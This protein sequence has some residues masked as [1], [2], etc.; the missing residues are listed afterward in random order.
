MFN[1]NPSGHAQEE[2]NLGNGAIDSAV[3]A[4]RKHQR[5]LLIGQIQ[6]GKTGAYLTIARRLIAEKKEFVPTKVI[7]LAGIHG[8]LRDQTQRRAQQEELNADTPGI[9]EV[10]LKNRADLQKAYD[11]V[12]ATLQYLEEKVLIID[13]ESDQASPNTRSDKNRRKGTHERSAVNAKLVELVEIALSPDMAGNERGRYLACTA[14]PAATLLV[15]RTDILSCDAAVLLPPHEEYFGPEDAIARMHV[16]DDNAGDGY[17]LWADEIVL[18]YF[19]GAAL[20]QLD[21]VEPPSPGW[22]LMAHAAQQIQ[23]HQDF[24]KSL[25]ASIRHWLNYLAVPSNSLYGHRDELLQ[26]ALRTHFKRTLD[27]TELAAFQKHAIDWL[28]RLEGNM[29]V[30]NN[31]TSHEDEMAVFSSKVGIVGGNMLSRGITLP[32]LLASGIVRP[33]KENTPYDTVQQWERFCGPR[34]KYENYLSILV[35]Q[36][37]KHAFEEIVSADKDLRA[38]LEGLAADGIVYL[39][40]WRRSF[41]LK[42]KN[43]TRKGVIPEELPQ[44]SFGCGW[45]QFRRFD[46][47]PGRLSGN[48]RVLEEIVR[49]FGL[50]QGSDAAFCVRDPADKA[51]LF[52]LLGRVKKPATASAEAHFADIPD[53]LRDVDFF[54]LYLPGGLL[55]QE[56]SVDWYARFAEET[57][58]VGGSVNNVFSDQIRE[59]R[60]RG[61]GSTVVTIHFRSIRAKVKAGVDAEPVEI[62]GAVYIPDLVSETLVGTRS[63]GSD[64]SGQNGNHYD[65]YRA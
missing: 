44:L 37:V 58:L 20:A 18:H 1:H 9:F 21:K 5:T 29:I 17:A 33:V 43:L 3:A 57:E 46:T 42:K 23:P 31:K 25:R 28:H 14:T 32:A 19:T 49:R 53:L 47:N 35:T 45:N 6:S 60:L 4:V 52:E 59:S 56:R 55:V 22:Q 54:D 40:M 7:I 15:P 48:K 27:D 50:Q 38:Q 65:Q 39:P 61:V 36:D 2:R 10:Y 8:H 30:V 62:L 63:L 16:L 13:D 26:A 64:P 11:S 12:V 51:A 24:E 34:K 41:L